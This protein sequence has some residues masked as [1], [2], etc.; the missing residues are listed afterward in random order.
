M[1]F[2]EREISIA[3]K[4]ASNTQGNQPNK[5]AESGTDT[6]T[7]TGSRTS[8]RV[9]NA[10]APADNRAQVRIWGMA[11]SLMNQ[12]T[13][14][15]L[16]FNL[17][18]KNTLTIS[19]GDKGS[20]LSAIFTGTIYA[21][22][23]DYTAQPDVPFIFECLSGVADA[24]APAPVTSFNGAADVATIMS[25]L[26]RQLNLGFENNNVS[27]SL[28]N[29]YFSGSLWSQAQTVAEHANIN[30][31]VFNGNLLSI[32]PKG[33]NRNTPSV[34]EISVDTGMIG[35]PAYT[36]QGII[37][38][39][40]FNPQIAFGGLV[41]V[42]SD[43]QPAT[44]QWSVNKLDLS[45]DSLLPKGDWKSTVFGYNPKYAKAILPPPSS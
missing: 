44:G 34:P 39:T 29:A 18:P 35:Y 41:K 38:Q 36:Q 12:L 5:F 45:L 19:A 15:G 7:L 23:G 27:A 25:G 32:W 11:P 8:V 37:V 16:V 6:V 1:S 2:V 31:G 28:H 22:Y 13:T 40:L 26:A 14:L 3:V 42:T 9:Q 20:S 10:G 17:V 24:V 30:W 4:L 33:G 43:L 21:A